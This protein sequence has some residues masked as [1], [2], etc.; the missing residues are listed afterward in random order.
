MHNDTYSVHNRGLML[1][2][3]HLLHSA[4][5]LSRPS[6]STDWRQLPAL[7]PYW[8][9]GPPDSPSLQSGPHFPRIHTH[10]SH[11][12][13]Y[14]TVSTDLGLYFRLENSISTVP[15][16][17]SW[18]CWCRLCK[19][20]NLICGGWKGG[21]TSKGWGS[22]WQTRGCGVWVL[23]AFWGTFFQL[24]VLPFNWIDSVMENVA[25][26]VGKMLDN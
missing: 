16:E 8:R 19:Y 10:L 9:A 21:R 25:W 15:D 2:R 11:T 17:D 14:M 7:F 13:C 1:W 12:V 20:C 18:C 5:S 4:A 23:S 6:L 24:A 3:A 26:W 22:C